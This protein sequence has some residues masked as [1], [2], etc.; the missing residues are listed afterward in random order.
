MLSTLLLEHNIF[1]IL[2]NFIK[3]QNPKSFIFLLQILHVPLSNF[4]IIFKFIQFSSNFH[5]KGDTNLHKFISSTLILSNT[6]KLS[7]NFTMLVV[8]SPHTS[9][10]RMLPSIQNYLQHPPHPHPFPF[11]DFHRKKTPIFAIHF[12]FPRAETVLSPWGEQLPGNIYPLIGARYTCAIAYMC[13]RN[14]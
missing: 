14:I 4:N 10:N 5:K 9:P 1:L 2:S 12:S 11:P 6:L 13:T 7:S 3:L 8:Q